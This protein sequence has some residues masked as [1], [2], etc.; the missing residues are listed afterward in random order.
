LDHDQIFLRLRQSFSIFP[1]RSSPANNELKELNVNYLH[2]WPAP[3]CGRATRALLEWRASAIKV[4][5]A[6]LLNNEERALSTKKHI[7]FPHTQVL[8]THIYA[9]FHTSL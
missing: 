6:K 3:T 4:K 9:D 2:M 1:R 7:E 8:H 5:R